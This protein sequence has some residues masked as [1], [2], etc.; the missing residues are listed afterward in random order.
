MS[1][2]LPISVLSV[3]G[4]RGWTSLAEPDPRFFQ[5]VPR[6]LSRRRRSDLQAPTPRFSGHSQVDQLG[7]TKGGPDKPVLDRAWIQKTLTPARWQE[8]YAADAAKR[9]SYVLAKI[10]GQIA[11]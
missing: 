9:R 4:P 3:M 7:R 8:T 2:C 11:G 5:V 10:L 1:W 6:G